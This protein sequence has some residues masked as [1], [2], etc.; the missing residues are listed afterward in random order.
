MAF[1]IARPRRSR[2]GSMTLASHLLEFRRRATRAAAAVLIGAIGGWFLSDF[3][4]TAIS[5]PIRSTGNAQDRLAEL[6]YD[7][8]T[9]AFDVRIQI[10][11]LVG[12]L[13]SSP[14]WLYQ[15]WAFFVPALTRTEVRYVVGFFAS[16]V[17]LFLA[18][19]AAGW[20]TLPHMV[21]LLSSFAAENTTSFI[22]ASDYFIFVLKLMIAIGVAFVL[23]VFIV[24]LNFMGLISA[25][26]IVRSWRIAVL[27]TVLFTA[28][29]TP[30]A[31][32]I[33][34]FALA[35]P[36]IAL[37]FAGAGVAAIHDRAIARRA[38]AMEGV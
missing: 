26:S 13:I 31:D 36:M 24:L 30:S 1:S 38:L 22:R 37:Y 19:C 18:G 27:V 17:P 2:D 20:I 5:A 10:A 23:P 8:L 11:I 34:M 25:R 28:I 3:V 14:V 33:A 32:V 12:I 6:N 35:V 7:T 16:A 29:A 21:Q 15:I 4:V 9:S